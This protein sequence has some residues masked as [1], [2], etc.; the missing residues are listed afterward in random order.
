LILLLLAEMMI[1]SSVLSED[2]EFRF[3]EQRFDA[4]E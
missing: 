1:R 2:D 3:E 4:S